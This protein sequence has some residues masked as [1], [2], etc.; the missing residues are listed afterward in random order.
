MLITLWLK[1]FHYTESRP[2]RRS[3]LPLQVPSTSVLG[4]LGHGYKYS[5]ETLN[6]GRIAIAA[7]ML[8]LAQGCVDRTLPYIKERRQF[9]QPVFSFQV[10]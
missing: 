8:G 2:L 6:E 1:F 3:C 7:Q 5:I 9:G 4:E 10:L